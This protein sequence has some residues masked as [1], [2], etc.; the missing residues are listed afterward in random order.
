[1]PGRKLDQGIIHEI[2]NDAKSCQTGGYQI[3]MLGGNDIINISLFYFGKLT[4]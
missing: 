1:M 4:R 2:V 3:L